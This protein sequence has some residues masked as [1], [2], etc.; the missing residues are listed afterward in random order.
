M[1]VLLDENLPEELKTDLHPHE[2]YSV[3]DKKWKGKK[4]GELMQLLEKE[5]FEVFLTSDKNLRHQQNLKNYS[6]AILLL[7]VKQNTY[8]AIKKLLPDILKVLRWKLPAGVT[9]IQ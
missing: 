3:R 1:K 8:P 9:V 2:V 4:N 5:E 7:D 6:V